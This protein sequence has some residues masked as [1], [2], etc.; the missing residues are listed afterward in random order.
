MDVLGGTGLLLFNLSRV[1]SKEQSDVRALASGLRVQSASDDPSGLA[2]SETLQ[3]K[4]YGLQQS[5]TNVQTAN[6]LLIVAENALTTVTNILQRIRSLIV[7]ARSDLNSQSNLQEIQAEIDQLLR[8]INKIGSTTTFNGLHLF[9]GSFDDSLGTQPGWTMV[10]PPFLAPD[11][12]IPSST[13]SNADGLGNPGPLITFT[14][15]TPVPLVN[16]Y[17]LPALMVFQ[18]TGYSDNAIDPD[19]GI[20]VGPGVFVTFSAYANDPSMGA[21]PLFVDT[22]A[23][24]INNGPTPPPPGANYVTPSGSNILVEGFTVAN[25]TPQDVGATFAFMTF[26]GKQP[27]SGR[28]LNVNDGGQ[29][30]TTIGISLPTISTLALGINT[31]S[32]LD[33]ATV[34]YLNQPTGQ[35]SSNAMSAGAALLQVDAAITQVGNVM[36]QIGAQMVATQEDATNDSI[37][38]LNYTTSESSIRDANVAQTVTDLT[39]QRILTDVGTTVLAQREVSAEQTTRL[40]MLSL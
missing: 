5:V 18:V 32:V 31:I 29:E 38:I 26:A 1:Q 11:G 8:E 30:G 36:A 4:I 9:D 20:N 7:E 34:N 23:V 28:P 15:N 3:S 24:P 10:K 21:A 14:G 2:I 25:L 39:L 12:S 40:L 27:G 19:T 6:N 33:P 16:G 22:T 37:A 35:S 17:F 13:V